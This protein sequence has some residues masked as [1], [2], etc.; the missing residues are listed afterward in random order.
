[1]SARK[2]R[3]R[4]LCRKSGAPCI[5]AKIAGRCRRDCSE[6]FDRSMPGTLDTENEIMG[7][8][9]AESKGRGLHR[10]ARVNIIFLCA[11][12]FLR[13]TYAQLSKHLPNFVSRLRSLK[14]WSSR[15]NGKRYTIDTP[16]EASDSGDTSNQSPISRSK[17]YWLESII[18]SREIQLILLRFRTKIALSLSPSSPFPL[19]LL[20][21]LLS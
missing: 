11:A 15:D 19:S 3:L 10:S 5:Y 8:Y 2:I 7:K 21:S 16:I 17:T 13:P 6:I 1:M 9:L 18:T 12:R 20:I 14:S 4:A